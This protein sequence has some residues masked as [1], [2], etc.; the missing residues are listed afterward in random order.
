[1]VLFPNSTH[2]FQPLDVAFFHPLVEEWRKVVRNYR[3]ENDGQNVQRSNFVLVLEF[4][5]ANINN[6]K[7][8][9]NGFRTTGLHSFD[10][11]AINYDK[12]LMKTET[13]NSYV[14]TDEDKKAC[15][16][17]SFLHTLETKLGDKLEAFVKCKSNWDRDVQDTSLYLLWKQ[18][19]V[20]AAGAEETDSSKDDHNLLSNE[21][22]DSLFNYPI[23]VKNDDGSFAELNTT[24]VVRQPKTNQIEKLKQETI[25]S[26]ES[27]QTALIPVEKN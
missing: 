26:H 11:D 21:E 24:E 4:A 13:I 18:C 1:M 22:S 8:L 16:E 17:S 6:S 10:P 3:I 20:S 19:K 9:S 5:L 14:G 27:Q 25:V 15:N 12:F 2:I 23:V 7:I